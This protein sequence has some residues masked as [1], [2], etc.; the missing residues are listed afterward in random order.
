[1]SPAAPVP[2]VQWVAADAVP[3]QPWRN[4]GG[5]TRELLAWPSAA[6]WRCRIS[7][8]DIG[9]DGPFSAFAG[10]ERWFTVLS[11]AGVVLS[12]PAGKQ[13]L[14]AGSAPLCFDGADA[15]GC[16]L[17]DGPTLDLNLMSRKGRGTMV[18]VVR[19]QAWG[20]DGALRALY[21]TAGG[22][23]HGSGHTLELPAHS[24]LWSDQAAGEPWRWD[25]LEPQG[26]QTQGAWWLSYRPASP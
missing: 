18:S 2:S 23:W 5:Q 14:L 22:R 19:G 16:R 4:G 12:L 21:T 13:R 11:G 7:R 17:I 25:P 20:D 26:P 24:L 10:V 9:A 8:A 1:V 6:D 3:P 15:P